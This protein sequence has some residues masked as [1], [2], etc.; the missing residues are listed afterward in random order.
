MEV[1]ALESMPECPAPWTKQWDPINRV[2]VYAAMNETKTFAKL[3]N[4][5]VEIA[6]D[7]HISS[8]WCK[9]WDTQNDRVVYY[10][11]R[12]GKIATSYTAARVADAK[13]PSVFWKRVWNATTSTVSWRLYKL[14]N[15]LHRSRA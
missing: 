4:L 5:L 6:P 13:A 2:G 10:N 12:S 7:T 15:N 1:D 9:E 11:I 14:S 3:E 8:D